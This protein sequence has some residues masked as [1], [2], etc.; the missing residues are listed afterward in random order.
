MPKEKKIDKD[1]RADM[2]FIPVLR[3]SAIINHRDHDLT[4]VAIA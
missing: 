2:F 3:T 1:R 4:V